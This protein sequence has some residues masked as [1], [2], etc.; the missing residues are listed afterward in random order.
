MK[1]Q[2][3]VQLFPPKK[4]KNNEKAKKKELEGKIYV[5]IRPNIVRFSPSMLSVTGSLFSPQKANSCKHWAKHSLF[6]T[7]TLC[8]TRP[9][10]SS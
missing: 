7:S 10:F 1:D 8:V 3:L 9:S 6:S 5:K 4:E 2:V